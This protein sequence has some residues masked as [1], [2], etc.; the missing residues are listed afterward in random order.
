MT[1]SLDSGLF[2]ENGPAKQ[3]AVTAATRPVARFLPWRTLDPEHR[4]K[5]VEEALRIPANDLV[6]DL[7]LAL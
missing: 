3:A 6:D 1:Y 5:A 7:P 4:L 2:V